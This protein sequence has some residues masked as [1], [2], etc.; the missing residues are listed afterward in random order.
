VLNETKQV[1]EAA[2][3]KRARLREIAE[4]C[5]WT[6]R[7]LT[8]LVEGVKGGKWFSLMDNHRWPNSYFAAHGLFSL[9]QAYELK[10]QSLIRGTH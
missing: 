7:M 3:W 5:V 9:K 8:A 10:R 2:L 1:E 4:P 6:E